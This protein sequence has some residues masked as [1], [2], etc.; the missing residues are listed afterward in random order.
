[1]G[2]EEKPYAN[3]VEQEIQALRTLS[4]ELGGHI[5]DIIIYMGIRAKE[6]YDQLHD[7]TRRPVSEASG[8]GKRVNQIL[9]KF[10]D[11]TQVREEYEKKLRA[12]PLEVLR[13]FRDNIGEYYYDNSNFDANANLASIL[14]DDFN[15]IIKEKS[16]NI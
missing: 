13:S 10:D 8:I 3:G 9:E 16:G 1:M 6:N 5:G 7:K 14:L 2:V 15:R 12:I 4:Q 11:I